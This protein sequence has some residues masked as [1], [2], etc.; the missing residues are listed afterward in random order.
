M[1]PMAYP[2][3]NTVHQLNF[4]KVEVTSSKSI[5]KKLKQEATLSITMFTINISEEVLVL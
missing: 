4:N 5:M 1:N 3:K 2:Q